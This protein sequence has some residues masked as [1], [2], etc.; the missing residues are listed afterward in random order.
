MRT[1]RHAASFG[2]HQLN[3]RQIVHFVLVLLALT[4]APSGAQERLTEADYNRAERMLAWMTPLRPA[5]G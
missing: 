5:H 2:R 1:N 3:L 4:A